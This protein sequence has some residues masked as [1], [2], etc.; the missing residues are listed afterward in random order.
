MGAEGG[1]VLSCPLHAWRRG[2][3]T[4]QRESNRHRRKF[5]YLLEMAEA[6]PRT[7]ACM[8]WAGRVLAVPLNG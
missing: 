5:V 3:V 1:H 4:G 8:M 6:A 2:A 7:G